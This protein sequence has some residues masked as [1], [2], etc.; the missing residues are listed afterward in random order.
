MKSLV[1]VCAEQRAD[2]WRAADEAR[3]LRERLRAQG[4]RMAA[5]KRNG[6]RF[7]AANENRFQDAAS[8]RGEAGIHGRVC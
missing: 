5:A 8:L 7:V 3:E 6:G 2:N 1:E 4:R